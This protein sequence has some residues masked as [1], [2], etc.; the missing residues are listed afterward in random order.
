MLQ[1]PKDEPRRQS[2]IIS[3]LASGF[4]LTTSHLWLIILPIS[5][6]IFY[7]LGPR[8]SVKGL[9]EQNL[10]VLQGEQGLVDSLNQITRL[11]SQFNLFTSLSIPLVGIPAL[12]SG[13][14]PDE[15]PLMPIVMEIDNSILWLF[16]FL[17]LSLVGILLAALYLGLIGWAMQREIALDSPSAPN[18]ILSMG[19]RC[20]RLIGLGIVFILILTFVLLPLLP[21]AFIF[22]L[23]NN[24]LFVAVL[25]VGFIFV[26]TYLSLAVPGIILN[27]R[28][29]FPAIIESIRLVHNNLRPT[30]GLF[31]VIL[32]IST[33]MN[34]LWHFADDGSWLTLA[35][36][37][38]HAF[39]S[40]SLAAA[41][42]VFYWDRIDSRE[43]SA[44]EEI[45][46]Q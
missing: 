12:M 18:F 41:I 23:L 42:F 33:G 24:V 36:I 11:A 46:E 34:Y 45:R 40:T 29:L 20:L 32:L 35:S 19:V 22:S 44:G 39:V 16:L 1:V 9:I 6:D 4:E 5:L 25:G 27:N 43:I 28:R 7:W 17:E 2:G 31:I 3:A 38:G 30:I 14:I 26:T 10:A 37:A 15:T 13:P 21:V 8:L